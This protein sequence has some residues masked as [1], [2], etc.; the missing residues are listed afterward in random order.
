[1]EKPDRPRNTMKNIGIVTTPTGA[2]AGSANPLKVKQQ[3]AKR[4]DTVEWSFNADPDTEVYYQFPS[5]L[6]EDLNGKPVEEIGPAP[7]PLIL[8]VQRNATLGYHQYAAFVY[9]DMKFVAQSSPPVIK[10]E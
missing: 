8:R 9:P 2:L 1:M 7:N 4:G 10:I 6:F 5:N 3:T